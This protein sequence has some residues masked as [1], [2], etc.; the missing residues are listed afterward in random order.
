MTFEHQCCSPVRNVLFWASLPFLVPQALRL[1][2]RTPRFDG[3]AGPNSGSIGRGDDK[4]L[5]VFGDSIAAGVGASNFRKAL[6][7]RTAASLAAKASVSVHWRSVGHIGANCGQ[8]LQQLD[9]SEPE[10]DIDYLVLSV[11]VNDVTSLT[12][13][14]TWQRNLSRLLRR[15]N[16]L[17]ECPVI[18]LCGLPPFGLFPALPQPLRSSMQMR[19]ISIDESSRKVIADFQNAHFAPMIFEPTREKFADDGYHP[20]EAGYEEYGRTMGSIL[21]KLAAKNTRKHDL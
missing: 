2:N 8:L 4:K 11:G 9:N 14:D 17:Y 3:A 15:L 7:G 6:A 13:I 18:V 21:A 1:K 10:N 5:L 12:T 20:S 19:A 16:L